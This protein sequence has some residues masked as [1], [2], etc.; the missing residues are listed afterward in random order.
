MFVVGGLSFIRRYT[1]RVR[2]NTIIAPH[3]LL[4]IKT[5]IS[6]AY[7]TIEEFVNFEISD[8]KKAARVFCVPEIQQCNQFSIVAR[9]T[10]SMNIFII[11]APTAMS[12]FTR[13]LNSDE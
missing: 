3:S 9:N 10:V 11:I 5:F 4:L 8:G 2:F 12:L 7:Q 1:L 6:P 13:K